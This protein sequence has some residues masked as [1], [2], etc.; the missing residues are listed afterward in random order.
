[1]MM[2]VMMMMMSGGV[3][4]RLKRESGSSF[5]AE[6]LLQQKEHEVR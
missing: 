3:F 4:S 1:M 6:Q 2:M 5:D